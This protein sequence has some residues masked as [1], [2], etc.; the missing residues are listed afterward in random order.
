MEIEIT[1][2][3]EQEDPFNYSASAS[4]MAGQCA[5]RITWKNALNC[6]LML[7]DTGEKQEAFKSW[8]SDFGAWGDEEI[9]AWNEKETN[10]LFIQ[11][12]S[13]E[14]REIGMDDCLLE[15]FNWQAYEWAVQEGEVA[16]N[17]FK[18]EENKIYFQLG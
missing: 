2:F 4:E 1:K 7:L 6:S 11:F 12:V 13:S 14:M 8:V 5:G 16:G 15:N 3:C 18:D 9:Q 17:I 10:A